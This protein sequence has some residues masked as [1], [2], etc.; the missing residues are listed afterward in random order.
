[1]PNVFSGALDEATFC[2]WW[3]LTDLVS[4]KRQQPVDFAVEA[5][6]LEMGSQ[7]VISFQE[8]EFDAK[9][10]LTYLTAKGCLPESSILPNNMP[11][12]AV[13]LKDYKTLFTQQGGIVEY[14]AKPGDIVKKGGVLARVLNVDKL[15]TDKA[16]TDIL[17]PCDLV[18]I[19]HFPSASVLSGTQLYKCFT[20]CFEL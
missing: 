16:T 12:K 15:D 7:E 13:M 19:L 17:A 2:P 20:E 6:T 8:G 5:F 3:L 11:R 4:A 1:M 10:I 14:L 9:S 18:A